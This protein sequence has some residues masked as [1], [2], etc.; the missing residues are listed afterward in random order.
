MKQQTIKLSKKYRQQIRL[1]G[2]SDEIANAVAAKLHEI[3][4]TIDQGL[5]KEI[6]NIRAQVESIFVEKQKGQANVE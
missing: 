3:K 1:S 5:G 6:Q 4:N 2:Q